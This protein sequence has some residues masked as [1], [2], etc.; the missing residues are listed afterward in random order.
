MEVRKEEFP[1]VL[2]AYELQDN[3]ELFIAEQVVNNQ[4]DVDAFTL[5]YAGKLIKAKQAPGM[6]SKDHTHSSYGAH[7]AHKKRSSAGTIVLII[8]IILI[9]LL[10]I[11]FAT[12]WIQQTFGIDL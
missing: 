11:G 12:G 8:V 10:V 3:K 7:G 5:R 1:V 6:H 9:I 4:G 2:Q